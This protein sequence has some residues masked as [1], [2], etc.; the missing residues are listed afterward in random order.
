MPAGIVVVDGLHSSSSSSGGIDRVQVAAGVH[1]DHQIFP[2]EQ[3]H[4]AERALLTAGTAMCQGLPL[5]WGEQLW[6]RVVGS[7][8]V[9][10]LA[11][12]SRSQ[13]WMLRRGGGILRV[14]R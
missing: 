4:E 12:H 6:G 2:E 3:G 9:Q 13:P 7:A 8:G 10:V 1:V 11:C 5:L 14:G